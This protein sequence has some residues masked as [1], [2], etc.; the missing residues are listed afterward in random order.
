MPEDTALNPS[1]I[2]DLRLTSSGRAILSLLGGD[3]PL[4]SGDILAG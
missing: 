2:E 4:L 3:I 1:Q